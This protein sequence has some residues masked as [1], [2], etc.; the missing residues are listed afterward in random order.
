MSTLSTIGHHSGAVPRAALTSLMA[1]A[2]FAS[3]VAHGQ[4]AASDAEYG[5]INKA[6]LAAGE[7]LHREFYHRCFI[8]ANYPDT[9]ASYRKTTTPIEPAKAFDNLY[10][11]SDGD[12]N[13]WILRTSEGFIVFDAYNNPAEA[14]EL[15]GGGMTKLGLDPN[16]IKYVALMHEHA[17]H[18]G[19][20][21]YLKEKYG[22]R[23]LASE[24]AWQTMATEKRPRVAY[25]PARDMVIADGQRL[26][27]GDTTVT[28]YVTPGHSAGSISAIFNVTDNG[29]RHVVG[30]MGGMGS[31]NNEANRNQ[32]I[33]SYTRWQT[34]AASA[35]VDALIAN[36]AA[37]D[38]A[39]EKVEFLR[40]RR[41]GAPNP[42]VVGADR[43]R[44]Y[45]EIQKDCTRARLARNKQRIDE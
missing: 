37:Q 36:H 17:D 9:I 32:I 38:N 45:F 11:I 40:V 14:L 24:A 5:Y 2:I 34:I 19:G 16:Q 21:K 20:S 27:L 12:N 42:L 3:G 6:R 26:T 25:A 39:I 10:F 35:G 44:R 33:K 13:V 29:V 15:I 41:P 8:D 7:D 31:P 28:F 18:Y 22:A 4:A 23:L 30:Y 43:H 1:L